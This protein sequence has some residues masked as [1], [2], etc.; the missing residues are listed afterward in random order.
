M[1]SPLDAEKPAMRM[2]LLPMPGTEHR[3]EGGS[4]HVGRKARSRVN[5]SSDADWSTEAAGPSGKLLC[6]I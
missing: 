5:D 4:T 3:G 2:R 1:L 6:N